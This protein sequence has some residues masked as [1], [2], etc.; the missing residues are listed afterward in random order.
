[1]RN[2][3][4]HRD[5]T[6]ISTTV[7]RSQPACG[8]LCFPPVLRHDVTENSDD[9]DDDRVAAH[10]HNHDSDPHRAMFWPEKACS[11]SIL[12]SARSKIRSDTISLF[13]LLRTL[14]TLHCTPLLKAWWCP[15]D[16]PISL[17][18]FQ[19]HVSY[20]P[21]FVQGDMMTIVV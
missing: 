12:I 16:P 17:S 15:L 21:F 20:A 13:L 5:I 3:Q 11:V 4:Y 10:H 14:H 18:G 8:A 19:S 1:M 6:T 2:L 9:D 7:A